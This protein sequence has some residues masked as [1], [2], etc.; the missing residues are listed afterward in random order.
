MRWA[1]VRAAS[2]RGWVCPMVP[3]TPRPSSRQIFGSWV[4]LPDPVSPATTTTW[5]SRI[6]AS[7]ASRRGR[8]RGSL[9]GGGGGAARQLLGVGDRGHR[10]APPRDARLGPL[11]LPDEARERAGPLV[12]VGRAARVGEAAHQPGGGAPRQVAPPP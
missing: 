4:V 6:A 12:R 3:R 1:T 8:A 2:R 11:D 7:R 9:G 5:L 10:G